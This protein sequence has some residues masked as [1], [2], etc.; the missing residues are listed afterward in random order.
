MVFHRMYFNLETHL[1]ISIMNRLSPVVLRVVL[2]DTHQT[3]WPKDNLT[4]EAKC[5]YDENKIM[6]LTI[7][8]IIIDAAL[9]Q[10]C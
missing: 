10:F 8:V 7:K 6:T 3:L 9:N 4:S 2:T 5:K 1:E